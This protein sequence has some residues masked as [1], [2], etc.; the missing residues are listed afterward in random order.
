MKKPYYITTPIYY[1]S[2][3]FHL[4][5]CY[6]TIICDAIARFKRMDGYDVFY[7]TGTNEHGQKVQQKAEAKG[8]TPKKFVDE[9]YDQIKIIV[10]IG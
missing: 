10:I 3:N 2:G 1:S 4:G 5:H 9:L 6:T 7:L 8:V